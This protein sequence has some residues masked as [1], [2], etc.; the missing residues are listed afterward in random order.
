MG[1]LPTSNTG[2]SSTALASVVSPQNSIAVLPLTL[3][4]G[5]CQKLQTHGTIHDWVHLPDLFPSLKLTQIGL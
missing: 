4:L 1:N 5:R 3:R 2:N